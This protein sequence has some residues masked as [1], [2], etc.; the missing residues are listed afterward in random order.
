MNGAQL[1]FAGIASD[2]RPPASVTFF[3]WFALAGLS[4]YGDL[5]HE[6]SLA[7]MLGLMPLSI[8]SGL[9]LTRRPIATAA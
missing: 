6:V 5:S 9:V 8:L 3:G 1:S 4:G 7:F 2:G